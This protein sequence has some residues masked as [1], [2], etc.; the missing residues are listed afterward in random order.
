MSAFP[1]RLELG[2]HGPLT[3]EPDVLLVRVLATTT[4]ARRRLETSL[5]DLHLD[6]ESARPGPAGVRVGGVLNEPPDRFWVRATEARS[7][8]AAE[9]ATLQATEDVDWVAPVYRAGTTPGPDGLVAPLP[10]GL[11]VR[12]VPGQ[13]RE[14]VEAVLA[15]EGLDYSAQRSKHLTGFLYF[16]YRNPAD[17]T[18]YQTAPAIP[19]R[20]PDV[21]AAV[22]FEMMP[23]LTPITVEPNDALYPQQWNMTQIGAG[24]TGTTGWD[25]TTG[26]PDVLICILDSGVDLTHPD[27]P[28]QGTGINLGSMGGT[29]APTGNHGTPCAGIAAATFGNAI[30]VAGV[31]GGCR[32]LPAAFQN[33]TDMEVANGIGWAIDND[34]DVIS[35][36]FG[37]Y[38]DDFDVIDP[39]IARAVEAR[40][41]MCAATGNDDY[42]GA[43]MHPARHPDVI[44]VGA[45]DQADNRKSPTSPDGECW[46]SNFAPGVSVTAPGVLIPTTD[47]QGAD[48]YNANGA[49]GIW[50]RCVEYSSF[51]DAAGNYVTVFNGTSAATPHVAGLAA[52]IRSMAPWLSA[53]EIRNV[54]ERTAA[55]VG[56]VPYA[57]EA[58]YPN[59]T[60]NDEMGYGRINV[61]AA[62]FDTLLSGLVRYSAV[63]HGVLEL[64]LDA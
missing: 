9:V 21:V 62:L 16:A 5:L 1:E 28:I 22:R 32:I 39:A 7:I 59:G 53:A 10:T 35:M 3:L 49:G 44:A 60:R 40:V 57:N 50:G 55:K 41:V 36:S 29:G 54:I 37:Q 8:E 58:G 4:P 23:M 48:G 13:P 31:A 30:G 2:T 18:H 46:G 34:A 43:N 56:T 17:P 33:W 64:L 38:G 26:R 11:L 63:R 14:A 47:I 20:Y 15:N 12:P 52:L 51:G 61:F 42:S 24:G 45:S 27:L 19:G 6:R 25:Y